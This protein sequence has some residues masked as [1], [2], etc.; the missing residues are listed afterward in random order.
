MNYN[1]G[2]C[3]YQPS[4]MGDLKT[5]KISDHE[6][7]KY[8]HTSWKNEGEKL[9]CNNCAEICSSKRDLYSHKQKCE[10]MAASL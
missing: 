10:L 8:Y 4:W 2:T 1:C 7:I 9:A 5:H 3:D 6:G